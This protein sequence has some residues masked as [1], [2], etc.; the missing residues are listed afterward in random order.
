VRIDDLAADLD[1]GIELGLD[2]QPIPDAGGD[3]VRTTSPTS[4][5]NHGFC[6]TCGH[7]FRR[8]DRVLVD[9]RARTVKHLVPNLTCGTVPGDPEPADGDELAEF[10]SGL[11]STW[12]AGVPVIRLTAT[13]P[14]IPRG[15]RVTK[16]PVC[17]YCGHSFRPG[18]YVVVCPCSRDDPVCGTAIH[19]DPA[20]G[21][22][23]WEQWRP[24][25]G[26]TICPVTRARVDHPD[27]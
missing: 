13:D 25:G 22:I 27:R 7:S 12:P 11:L 2:P 5:W 10:A 6:G 17:L 16:P 21:L 1:S 14:R 18:E 24:S 26:V 23:C 8:G 3:G 4:W 15:P 19:R 9:Q 20:I